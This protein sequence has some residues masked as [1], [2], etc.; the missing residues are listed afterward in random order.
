MLLIKYIL[1]LCFFINNELLCL[2]CKSITMSLTIL[3]NLIQLV[4]FSEIRT[5]LKKCFF[6]FDLNKILIINEINK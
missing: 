5:Y 4:C 1:K 6:F 3:K 2:L